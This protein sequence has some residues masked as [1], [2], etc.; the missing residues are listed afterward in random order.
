MKIFDFK[1]NCADNWKTGRKYGTPGYEKNYYAPVGWIGIALKVNNLYENGDNSWL[2]TGNK[3]GAW[4]AAY[5]PIKTINSIP[6]IL[7]NGFRRGPYQDCK[8]D[9]N[10]NPLTKNFHP[11]CGKGVYFIPYIIETKNILKFLNI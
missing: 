4:Y 2:E 10:I 5:H 7:Y 6:D 11:K 3:N 9:N 1:Y 8:D